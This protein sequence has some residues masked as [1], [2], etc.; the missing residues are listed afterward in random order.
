MEKLVKANE[1]V[2]ILSKEFSYKFTVDIIRRM[3]EK[4]QI[5]GVDKRRPFSK[6][7]S[8]VYPVEK[9]I[10]RLKKSKEEK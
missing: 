2:G 4:G 10:E 8:W 1:L 6:R 5:I 7:A 9:N 3:R